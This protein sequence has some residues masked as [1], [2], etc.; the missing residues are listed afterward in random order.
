MATCPFPIRIKNPKVSYRNPKPY[1]DVPCGKC[2][3][4][5]YNRKMEWIVRLIH[6]SRDNHFTFFCTLTYSDEYLPLCPEC[7]LP[8]LAK[9]DIMDFVNNA[10]KMWSFLGF[11]FRYFVVGE[12]GENYARPHFHLLCFLTELDCDSVSNSSLT[13]DFFIKVTQSIWK[14]GFIHS[15]CA[16][17]GAAA[18]CAKYC[19]KNIAVTD[20]RCPHVNG[21]L[22]CS[23]KP[24][25]GHSFLARHGDYL[26]S[27]PDVLSLGINQ[28]KYRIPRAYIKKLIE[29]E[30]LYKFVNSYYRR[31]FANEASSKA[32]YGSDRNG[33]PLSDG[34]FGQRIETVR[35]YS[36]RMHKRGSDRQ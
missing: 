24:I 29:N 1:L 14:Y 11:N 15:G 20:G 34:G 12:Y 6:E 8:Y 18:Y 9:G 30:E 10:K 21:Y 27:H 4:C 17:D 13:H 33:N 36:R 16:S 7:G 2:S 22:S 26:L 32:N 28:Y 23:R 19:L 3:V 25:I 5:E 31:K 35:N